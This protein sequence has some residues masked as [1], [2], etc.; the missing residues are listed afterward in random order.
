MSKNIQSITQ[1]QE[2]LFYKIEESRITEQLKI[3]NQIPKNSPMPYAYLGNFTSEFSS[4]IGVSHI[5]LQQKIY[6]YSRSDNREIMK[7]AEEISH[8]LECQSVRF[9]NINIKHIIF[10]N[11]NFDVMR[12]GKT[13]EAVLN[14]K[15]KLEVP[16]VSNEVARIT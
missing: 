8:A 14:F 6:L 7:F 9:Q 10:N 16:N 15:I 3:Y 12:D 13:Y 2:F 4:S 11:M 1:F 5:K